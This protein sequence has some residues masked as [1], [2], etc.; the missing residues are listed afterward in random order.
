VSAAEVSIDVD[1]LSEMPAKSMLALIAKKQEVDKFFREASVLMRDAAPLFRFFEDHNID[2][3]IDSDYGYVSF[4]FTGTGA[5]F[6]EVWSELRRNGFTPTQRPK[7]GDVEFSAYW[8]RPGCAKLFMNFSSSLCKRVQVGT[9]MV[10][11]PIY[12]TQCGEAL[13]E[14]AAEPEPAAALTAPSAALESD[15]PF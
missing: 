12:E 4:T 14:I 1:V 7:K 3:R 5:F 13:P 9:K 6:S 10:E 2:I 11:Q 8:E 15:I